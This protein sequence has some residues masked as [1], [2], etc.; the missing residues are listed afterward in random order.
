[1]SK[2]FLIR[3]IGIRLVY[4]ALRLEEPTEFSLGDSSQKSWSFKP[5]YNNLSLHSYLL[6]RLLNSQAV[7]I[8]RVPDGVDKEGEV[9]D[10]DTAVWLDC[11]AACS[12]GCLCSVLWLFYHNTIR[13]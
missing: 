5:I 11:S 9:Q 3:L 4:I 12:S 13:N 2:Y 8:S 7:V 1:M 6:M 10:V